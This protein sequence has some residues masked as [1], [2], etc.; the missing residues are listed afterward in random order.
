MADA[1]L[2]SMV[3]IAFTGWV[4]WVHRLQHQID[5]LRRDNVRLRARIRL[6]TGENP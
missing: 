1:V 2:S 6:M 3:L 4:L 5:Q